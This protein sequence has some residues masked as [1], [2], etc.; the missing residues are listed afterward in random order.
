MLTE[1]PN[2]PTF[3]FFDPGVV[4]ASHHYP[5][6]FQVVI[7]AGGRGTRLMEETQKI[8]KPM[9]T[10]GENTLLEHIID[11]YRV[12]GLREFLIPVGYK[13]EIIFDYFKRKFELVYIDT[14][15]C[16]TGKMLN[17]NVVVS[18][19]NTGVD[20]QTGGR[21]RRLQPRINAPFYLTYGDGLGN[22]DLHSLKLVHESN[23]AD[24]TLT[25][26]HPVARFGALKLDGDLVTEFGEKT[27]F[28]S[29]WINGGFMLVNPSIFEMIDGDDTN[30]E[31]DVLPY[32]ASYGGL[33]AYKHEDF[34]RCCDIERDLV[35]LREIYEDI[36]PQWLKITG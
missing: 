4:V 13:K 10:V 19:I 25:A 14:S 23:D 29:G 11:I 9:L 31:A 24:V 35:T 12:Q 28:L 30:L 2:I 17:T 33:A 34:W 3:P 7:L 26:V 22:V 27:D 6:P 21:I 18:I 32:I 36:G 20:T 5:R 16:L 15:D 8:P 1:V